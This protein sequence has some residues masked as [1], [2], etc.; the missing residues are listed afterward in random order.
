MAKMIPDFGSDREID[1]HLKDSPK[2]EIQVYK[3]LKEKLPDTMY[4]IHSP[5]WV[6]RDISGRADGEADFIVIDPNNGILVIEV[7]GGRIE[8]N[9]VSG[10][11]YSLNKH[12]ERNKTKDP[13]KQASLNKFAFINKWKQITHPRVVF[14][15]TSHAV[16]F[17]DVDAVKGTLPTNADTDIIINK[18]KLYSDYVV[19]EIKKVFDFHK[20]A[21][22]RCE[23]DNKIF[24]QALSLFKNNCEFKTSLKADIKYGNILI[25][26]LTQE[27]FSILKQT[28]RNKQLCII[29]GAGTGK[30]ILAMEKAKRLSNNG[31]KVL[32][33][34]HNIELAKFIYKQLCEFRNI[35]VCA[36][37]ILVERICNR[38][39]NKDQAEHS[40]RY[41]KGKS[42]Q[43]YDKQQKFYN[44]E[45]P[46]IL[47][48]ASTLLE[49][50]EKYDAV[51]IDEAQDFSDIHL[52]SLKALLS[53][54][55][56]LY[57][58][59]DENQII[60]DDKE[61]LN[62]DQFLK[63]ELTK[64]LRNTEFIHEFSKFFKPNLLEEGSGLEGSEVE[65][66]IAKKENDTSALKSALN[67]LLINE[68]VHPSEIAVFSGNS[69]F[70]EN[71]WQW[72]KLNG[73]TYS[74]TVNDAD[75]KILINSI[76]KLKGIERP[77]VIVNNIDWMKP[78]RQKDL[79]ALYVAATRAK[80]KL[81]IIATHDTFIKFGIFD[82]Q[83]AA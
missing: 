8:Y 40:V 50:S 33:V 72:D 9:S 45:S 74:N 59:M 55:E 14:I 53:E 41:A 81:V 39:K 7:K 70:K 66:V 63:L 20:K 5:K 24:E 21:N 1:E 27:Q 58:F 52:M 78:E 37:D 12:N 83:G 60:Y 10:Q 44:R 75:D 64:N 13:F 22:D 77:V 54:E 80:I 49:D 62:V 76:H 16:C 68:Q 69:I 3:V 15:P 25:D 2:S 18:S 29:G 42:L 47:F 31:K 51:I 19:D 43:D 79:N 4:V 67:K 56:I 48:S 38:I 71:A 6:S 26:K 11:W 82:E 73:L 36:Y 17:P 32:L 65:F 35:E 28:E 34:C 61:T 57:I 30:T 23:F 46:D